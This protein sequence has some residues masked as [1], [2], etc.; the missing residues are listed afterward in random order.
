MSTAGSYSG[1]NMPEILP[2][3]SIQCS[4]LATPASGFGYLPSTEGLNTRCPPPSWSSGAKLFPPASANRAP[5]AR[6]GVDADAG[7]GPG[8][9]R[10]ARAVVRPSARGAPPSVFRVSRDNLQRFPLR[11]QGRL[12]GIGVGVGGQWLPTA[13]ANRRLRKLYMQI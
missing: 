10:R 3:L 5:T 4:L 1:S 6:T 11:A 2:W 7:A 12:I 9:T 8:G 13:G